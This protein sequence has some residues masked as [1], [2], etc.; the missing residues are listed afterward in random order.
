MMTNPLI[1][2]PRF[3]LRHDLKRARTFVGAAFAIARAYGTRFEPVCPRAINS[4][5]M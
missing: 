1:N 3:L 4:R 2:T 5:P